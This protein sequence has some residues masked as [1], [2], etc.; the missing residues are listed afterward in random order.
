MDEQ[1]NP[2]RPAAA[3][4]ARDPRPTWI[5]DPGPDAYR[6]AAAYLAR[7]G[8]EYVVALDLLAYDPEPE[9]PYES[10]DVTQGSCQRSSRTTQRIS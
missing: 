2:T 1:T 9:P 3:I 6:A 4:A 5:T 8:L 10:I 7:K